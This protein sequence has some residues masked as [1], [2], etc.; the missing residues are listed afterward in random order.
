ML[1]FSAEAN[2]MSPA[3]H[4]PQVQIQRVLKAQTSVQQTVQR[5]LASTRELDDRFLS[6]QKRADESASGYVQA[7]WD[8]GMDADRSD[9]LRQVRAEQK[10]AQIIA[11]KKVQMATEV[12]DLVDRQIER[13]DAALSQL[14]DEFGPLSSGLPPL[15]GPLSPSI[16]GFSAAPTG[17]GGGGGGGP[18]YR[19]PGGLAGRGL[20]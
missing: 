18:G 3:R 19:V 14:Q 7:G 10:S 20:P 9:R 4:T 15:N 6:A 12:H 11:D 13:L 2:P 1:P 8:E 17:G 16:G 5:T